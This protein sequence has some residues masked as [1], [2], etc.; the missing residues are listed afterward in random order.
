VLEELR[1]EVEGF[2]RL[3]IVEDLPEELAPVAL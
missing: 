2:E 1:V 3:I